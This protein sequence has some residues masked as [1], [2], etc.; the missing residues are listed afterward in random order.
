MSGRDKGQVGLDNELSLTEQEHKEV[1]CH[2][3]NRQATIGHGESIKLHTNP[4][5]TT[6]DMG[7]KAG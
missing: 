3:G 4:N 2:K 1:G 5:R 6:T 7:E